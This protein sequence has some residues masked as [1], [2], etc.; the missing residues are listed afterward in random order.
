MWYISDGV[1][2]W[3]P[4]TTDQLQQMALHPNMA[5]AAPGWPQWVPYYHWVQMVQQRQMPPA[6][7]SGG[8]SQLP[9]ALTFRGNPPPK[10]WGKK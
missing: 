3:G 10:D 2:C 9:G 8:V 6:N 1:N 4:Y 7:P 5:V